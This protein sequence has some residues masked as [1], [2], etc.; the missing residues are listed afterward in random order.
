MI[1]SM[2]ARAAVAGQF[3]TEF[4]ETAKRLGGRLSENRKIR[5]LDI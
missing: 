3:A 2:A 4:G 1:G 5:K